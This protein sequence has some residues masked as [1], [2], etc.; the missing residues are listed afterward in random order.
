VPGPGW[1]CSLTAAACGAA[2]ASSQLTQ[3]IC[4]VLHQAARSRALLVGHHR[5]PVEKVTATGA[6]GP[7]LPAGLRVVVSEVS[8]MQSAAASGSHVT[9]STS[10]TVRVS[11]RQGDLRLINRGVRLRCTGRSKIGKSES[12]KVGK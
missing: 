11:G 8:P 12:R 10:Y 7:L 5:W 6:A 2:M 9:Q 1:S 3:A 4:C